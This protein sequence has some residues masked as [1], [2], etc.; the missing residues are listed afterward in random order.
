MEDIKENKKADHSVFLKHV[1]DQVEE[2]QRLRPEIQQLIKTSADFGGPFDSIDVQTI[3]SFSRVNGDCEKNLSKEFKVTP[4]QKTINPNEEVAK[5]SVTKRIHFIRHG[6]GHHNVAFKNGIFTWPWMPKDLPEIEQTLKNHPDFPYVDTVLTDD[7][8]QQ[9]VSLQSY[10]RQNCPDCTLL[11]LSPMRRATQTGLLAFSKEIKELKSTR[12]C[13]LNIVVKEEA[14]ESFSA[15]PCDIRLDLKELETFFYHTHRKEY[16]DMLND[17]GLALDYSQGLSESDPFWKNGLAR[18]E[19]LDIAKRGCKLLKWIYDIDDMEVA[20][21][22]HA[23]FLRAIFEGVIINKSGTNTT[24][25]NGEIKT[26]DV[27]FNLS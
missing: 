21:A 6:E 23:G 27:T 14:H 10:I 24:F 26:C 17:S 2:L 18:E 12:K 3:Q 9:A 5:K 8:E 25:L 13:P 16:G 20:I 22:A 11:I 7:G 15:H 19:R 1:T 4:F